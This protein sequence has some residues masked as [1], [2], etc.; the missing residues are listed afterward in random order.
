MTILAEDVQAHIDRFNAGIQERNP[1]EYEFHQ[2]VQEFTEMVLLYVHLHPQY[3]D[4]HIL[5]RMTEPDRIVI[6]RYAGKTMKEPSAATGPG[7]CNSIMRSV[8]TKV[9]CA[10]IP[11]SLRVS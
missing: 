4:A 8:L 7:V 6:F 10:F 2:A 3:R 11:A 9:V 5:E 1:G